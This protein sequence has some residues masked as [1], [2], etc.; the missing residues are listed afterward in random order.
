MTTQR[1][2]TLTFLDINTAKTIG[3]P[4]RYF[5]RQL[6]LWRNRT[7]VEVHNLLQN[8]LDQTKF[9]MSVIWEDN[10]RT[11]RVFKAGYSIG[12]Q[13]NSAMETLA[14]EGNDNVEVEFFKLVRHVHFRLPDQDDRDFWRTITHN[15]NPK[16]LGTLQDK[17]YL[18]QFKS[19]RGEHPRLPLLPSAH[20]KVFRS[21][22]DTNMVVPK[23]L[24]E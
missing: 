13:I 11:F 1:K 4:L 9:R 15:L 10:K 17:N 12:E 18:S 22:F 16:W 23:T 6:G 7:D 3:W 14:G 20:G 24:I 2:I 8:G 19:E 21:G 5:A